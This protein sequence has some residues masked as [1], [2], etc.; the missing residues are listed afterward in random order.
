[1]KFLKIILLS[2]GLFGVEKDF[3]QMA[4]PN[5]VALSWEIAFPTGN[6]FLSKTS[7]S[8][9]RFEYRYMVQ[10][11]F[12]AGLAVSWNS[13]DQYF[14]TRTYHTNNS[15]V[16]TDMVREIYTAPITAIFHY[17]PSARGKMLKPF[18]G[19][20]LGAQYAEQNTYFNIYETTAN[21][22]GFVVRPEIGGLLRVGRGAAILISGSYNYATNK[23]SS[24]NISSLQQFAI[25]IG[26][27]GLF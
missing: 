16:T 23:N 21:N 4:H 14:G 26:I 12:S 6:D 11:N 17:Y 15:A 1:M 10:P 8:G 22:W 3:A 19:I 13:F 7:F 25:N 27:A 2:A 20:G 5:I 18:I 24:F 9:G